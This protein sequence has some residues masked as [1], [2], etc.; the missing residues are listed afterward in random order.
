MNTNSQEC[1]IDGIKYTINEFIKKW[2]ACYK[3]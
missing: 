3:M 1:Y 2:K